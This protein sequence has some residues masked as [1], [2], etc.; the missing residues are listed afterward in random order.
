MKMLGLML[1]LVISLSCTKSGSNKDSPTTSQETVQV[2]TVEETLDSDGDGVV[3]HIEA[4]EGS[5]PFIADIPSIDDYAIKELG[6]YFELLNEQNGDQELVF[7]LIKDEQVYFRLDKSAPRAMRR[8]EYLF[9]SLV[10]SMGF[11]SYFKQYLMEHN[12]NDELFSYSAPVFNE[13][14][15]FEI[16]Q[17][18]LELNKKG[19]KVEKVHADIT[20]SFKVS[21]RKYSYFLNPV[22]DVYYRDHHDQIIH[23]STIRPEGK[24]SFNKTNLITFSLSDI[25]EGSDREALANAGARLFIKLSDFTIGDLGKR[26]SDVIKDIRK[27]SI[28]V[29]ML[30]IPE[31]GRLLD[32]AK[33]IYVG[34]NG[35]SL[36]TDKIFDIASQT[37][38]LKDLVPLQSS[39]SQ[40]LIEH[41][42]HSYSKKI[43][44]PTRLSI[45]YR[46]PKKSKIYPRIV[47]T[48]FLETSKTRTG[49]AWFDKQTD[50]IKF[51]IQPEKRIVPYTAFEVVKKNCESN[52]SSGERIYQRSKIGWRE[53]SEISFHELL[54]E[55]KIEIESSRERIFSG[56]ATYL[57]EDD[58]GDLVISK[59]NGYADIIF[60]KFE[61]ED[62]SVKVELLPKKVDVKAGVERLIENSCV[63]ERPDIGCR[64]CSS[65][66][67]LMSGERFLDNISPEP[68]NPEV[69]N[70]INVFMF[71]Y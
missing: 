29:T 47:K 21:S 8:G 34:T 10:P 54:D 32:K 7:W 62:I 9:E 56:R 28:Q 22:F 58:L 60:R 42:R 14:E 63:R 39:K 2:N 4:R 33:T 52:F 53:E 49:R 38:Y 13:E 68:K 70:S 31:E 17:R 43:E 23:V 65:S 69:Q 61:Y 50:V 12:Y 41:D 57:L 26:Y 59:D 18:F 51:R 66:K 40:W 6:L 19:Y 11:Q 64:R 1:I 24:Y 44:P 55:I 3:D 37:D 48:E 20:A 30:A 5:N 67:Q 46:S 15:V 36:E 27:K 45:L 35:S 25:E 16:S 71:G